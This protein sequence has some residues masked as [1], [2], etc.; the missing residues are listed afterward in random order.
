MFEA[1]IASLL[2]GYVARYVDINA[3]QLSVQLL[4]G[5][6]IVVENLTFNKVTLNND[7]QTKLKL[8]IEI[9]SLHVG[10]IQCS[11]VWSSFFFRSSSA[12][13]IIKIEHVRAIIKPIILD[14][15]DNQQKE[16][17][18]YNQENEIV[19]KQNLLDLAEQELEKEFEYLGEVK[20]SSWS[21]KRLILS[22]LE[23]LQIQIID[24]HISYESF[25]SDNTPYTVGLAFDNIQISNELSNENMNRKIFQVHNLALYAD[26]NTN[27]DNDNT[28]HSYIL[29]PSNSIKIY[30]THNY[31][32]KALINR[33]QPR[34]ELEWTFDDLS[35][36]SSVEQIKILSD[37]IRFIQYSNTHRKFMT[38]PSRPKLKISKQTAKL[39]WRYITLVLIRTQNYLKT[40]VSN[41]Q[42]TTTTA[43]FWFNSKL[44]NKRLE[45]LKTYKQLYRLYLDNKYLKRSINTNFTSTDRL[46]MNDIELEF[47]LDILLRIRRVIFRKRAEE[48]FSLVQNQNQPITN[49]PTNSWYMSYAKWISSKT[50][51][52]WKTTTP[53]TDNNQT[54]NSTNTTPLNENDKKLQEQ[55]ST[56][57]AQSLEDEDLSKQRRDAL[58]LRL[59]FVIKSLQ[60]DLVSDDNDDILFNFLLNNVSVLTELRPRH[61]SVL[62]YVRL[63]DL[64]I[65][66]RLRTDAFSNIVCPKQR[67][68]E[69]VIKI[70]LVVSFFLLLLYFFFVC[71]SSFGAQ[72]AP[73]FE[74]SY[75][76]K[77][78]AQQ[79]KTKRLAFSIAVRSRGLCFVCCPIS[80]ER[81]RNFFSAALI[82]PSS[83]SST[84]LSPSPSIL[85]HWTQLKDRTTKQI[86]S[87]FEQ[88]FSTTS[89]SKM[90]SSSV[91]KIKQ[92]QRRYKKNFD[93]Y[94]DICAPQMI[95]PQSSDRALIMD[96]GYLTF[97]N[98]EYRRSSCP[99]QNCD[100]HH[101]GSTSPSSIT[102]YFQ[103]RPYFFN[104]QRTSPISSPINNGGG[105]GGG[106]DDDDEFLTPE[107]SPLATDGILETET[108][109]YPVNIIPREHSSSPT[110]DNND[111]MYSSFSLSL[112]DM[113]LGYLT[114]S[115]NQ[116]T[117]NLSA[118]IEKFGVCFL[119]QYRTIETF[120]P[121]LPLIKVS[122]IIPKII[123]HLDPL[124][125]E[126]LC[127]IIN[128]WGLFVE[129]LPTSIV[130]KSDLPTKNPKK[131][132]EEFNARL[133]LGFRINEIS[134]QLSDDIRA[135]SEIRI[136]YIDLTLMNRINSNMLS[137][138]VQT[139]MI[140]DALQNHGK[141]YELILTSN[142]ALDI[143]TQTGTLYEINKSSFNIDNE[144][145]IRINIQSSTDIELDENYLTTDIHV[146]KLH[147][148][149][150]PETLSI[151]INFFVSIIYQMKTILRQNIREQSDIL[152]RNERKKL[153]KYHI[154]SE[155]QELSILFTNVLIKKSSRKIVYNTKLEKI[156]AARIKLA[157]LKIL[158]EP[159]TFI[160]AK[161]S[162][163]KIFNLLHDTIK[164]THNEQSSAIIDLGIEDKKSSEQDKKILPSEAFHLIYTRKQ[165][166]TN[167]DI[168]DLSIEMASVC[169]THSPKILFKIEQILKYMAQ[170]CH[171]TAAIQ[172]ERMKQNMIRQ[173][174][175][176][177]NQYVLPTESGMIKSSNSTD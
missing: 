106:D 24:V 72:R 132:P 96:F 43:K 11:F 70:S 3:D 131:S 163:L 103:Q 158:I 86:K 26:S 28:N 33:R 63:D 121:L 47:D 142:R 1:V 73:V 12:A 87:A 147:F 6:P 112:C 116:S 125:I 10:K 134:I 146:N 59:K 18:E 167:N 84:T 168:E 115:N 53:T 55:V 130:S 174:S 76:I 138:S 110:I 136:Q 177:L 7:I 8:P 41:E 128:N 160:E 166:E 49:E 154:N 35:L 52:I 38:D 58:Y 20:S 111:I 105:G 144:Y 117:N 27:K 50:V 45:Q 148:V 34:Y 5:R 30:L 126:T 98:D 82:P 161:I 119:I 60:I 156:A 19:K 46:E 74:L 169:Y 91:K 51:D 113:Q 31:I 162:S 54:I 149:F 127:G 99:L 83:S 101:T 100:M 22:F 44:L 176:L 164:I 67:A 9:E 145:L 88:I 139:L 89:I 32:R 36:K 57:I 120:D 114:Y 68:Q 29:L 85:Q 21:L 80:V 40:P 143:N 25:T 122:G 78:P 61:E 69:Y 97:I 93:I 102:D 109:N 151:L 77:P 140:I 16:D 71:R 56:F 39:W 170:H 171:S 79:P 37:V 107:S 124:R 66:D 95:I 133:A 129:N 159:T 150:N 123:L 104:E 108:I 141:D 135:L 172:M 90:T 157:S 94:L 23:K 2:K 92:G 4:Y 155:F 75:E 118:I 165:D 62:F 153:T 173:G 14:D 152:P 13:F 65:C 15:N 17:E 42:T 48:Q 137:F 64:N 175:I 81:L